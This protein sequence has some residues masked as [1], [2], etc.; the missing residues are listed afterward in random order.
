MFD[1]ACYEPYYLLL[2]EARESWKY[3]V[4]DKIIDSLNL[5]KRA[6]DSGFGVAK[7]YLDGRV[8]IKIHLTFETNGHSHFAAVLD[9][10]IRLGTGGED[11]SEFGHAAVNGNSPVFIDIAHEIESPEQMAL[12]RLPISSMVRLK[13]FNH[14][15]CLCGNT[16]RIAAKPPLAVE[17]QLLD[18]RKLGMDRVIQS[19]P[20]QGEGEVIQCRASAV[21]EIA[22][23]ESGAVG[24]VHDL[25]PDDV[26]SI[27][28][29]FFTD[30][31][32]GFRFVEGIKLMP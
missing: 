27:L 29:V 32:I 8:W 7:D 18:D 19:Q 10:D 3:T 28:N 15:D 5:R 24:N 13:G 30:Q 12:D 20:G 14:T 31:G 11:G 9:S 6:F 25:L 21:E 23:N 22:E 26:D 1:P 4:S 2:K 16:P 17:G